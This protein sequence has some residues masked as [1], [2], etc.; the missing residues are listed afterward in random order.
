MITAKGP[1]EAAQ[2]AIFGAVIK[3][4]GKR[5][6]K[7]SQKKPKKK[8]EK[9]TGGPPTFAYCMKTGLRI[10]ACFKLF[11]AQA[12]YQQDHPLKAPKKA[13]AAATT[14]TSASSQDE[15]ETGFLSFSTFTT[16]GEHGDDM[17]AFPTISTPPSSRRPR[18]STT[19]AMIG[20]LQAMATGG[21]DSLG[22]YDCLLNTAADCSVVR[23]KTLLDN[24]HRCQ[25]VNFDGVGGTLAILQ[26]GRL[27]PL[28]DAYY[29]P[30]LGLSW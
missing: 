4:T 15:E 29:H 23:N 21:T 14:G 19:Y 2:N 16:A 20:R 1:K 27:G 24:L 6:P 3:P 28:C 25:A 26:K 7:D 10:E 17:S 13:T 8:P 18:R 11:A 22:P 30:V 9:K 5:K 12:K